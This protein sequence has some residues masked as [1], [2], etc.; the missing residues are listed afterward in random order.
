MLLMLGLT[1]S[2]KINTGRQQVNQQHPWQTTGQL[3]NRSVLGTPSAQLALTMGACVARTSGTLGIP[4]PLQNGDLVCWGEAVTSP[5]QTAFRVQQLFLPAACSGPKQGCPRPW[6]QRDKEK[7][8]LKEQLTAMLVSAMACSAS[9][10]PG[11]GSTQMNRPTTA[12]LDGKHTSQC[13][14]GRS[15]QWS[16]ANRAHSRGVLRTFFKCCGNQ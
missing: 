14:K 9:A 6:L 7:V 3:H 16:Q 15:T 1:G 13:G 5:D 8:S 10:A 12:P 11:K 4:Q 2:K